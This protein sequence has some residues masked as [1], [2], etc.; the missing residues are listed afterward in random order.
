MGN[1]KTKQNMETQTTGFKALSQPHSFIDRLSKDDYDRYL[2]C[3]PKTQGWLEK[4]NLMK[5]SWERLWFTLEDGRV[6]YSLR[7]T[8][9]PICSFNMKDVGSVRTT[10]QL[11]GFEIRMRKRGNPLKLREVD[12]Q[13]TKQWLF[14]FHC[15]V[16]FVINQL[17]QEQETQTM[18]SSIDDID[19]RLSSPCSDFLSPLISPTSACDD[20]LFEFDDKPSMLRARVVPPRIQTGFVTA[21]GTRSHM[22]DR[23][24]IQTDFC[25]KDSMR[26][27]IGVFD[28]HAGDEAAD[29]AL[30]R[31]PELI[32]RD[33]AHLTADPKACLEQCFL[34]CDREFLDS[35]AGS[36][37]DAGTTACVCVLS[38]ASLF[39]ANAGDC[40]AVLSR[41][42]VA[43]DL[44][45]EHK[46]ASD[47]ERQ[48]IESVG[49][50]VTVEHELALEQL[51]GLKLQDK[52]VRDTAHK[53]MRFVTIGRVNGELSVSRG[54][55]D[56]RFKGEKAFEW[57]GVTG[58]LVTA[59]PDV[60]QYEWGPDDNF[61]IVATDGLWDVFSS[62][63]AVDFVTKRCWTFSRDP[64]Q[65]CEELK[66]EALLRGSLDNIT[67][68]YAS[69]K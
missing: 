29:H 49:G 1:R 58:D 56:Q 22:E 26:C 31:L 52:R 8:H 15:T 42:N 21:Q 14:A 39:V 41:G 7:P 4:Y 19:V 11:G 5:D 53:S 43:V 55:G 17:L 3:P 61:I 51:S 23:C 45:Q 16:A 9:E 68:A 33:V 60:Y 27:L 36:E 10:Q 46:P 67:V 63:E 48:R 66:E 6:T 20:L 18:R 32:A 64:K 24:V 34:E 28:G 57:E 44:C 30:Y 54:F 37:L 50:R 62:Q 47:G 59:S 40:K 13:E 25:D 35:I 12:S 65:I 69:L 38:D 2:R